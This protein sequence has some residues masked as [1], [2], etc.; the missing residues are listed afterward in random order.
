MHG[1]LVLLFGTFCI[2]FP[3]I[4]LICSWLNPQIQSTDMESQLYSSMSYGHLLYYCKDQGFFV[5]LFLILPTP[6]CLYYYSFIRDLGIWQ[7]TVH[8]LF[9]FSRYLGFYLGF[10][11]FHIN[12]R[13]N[14]SVSTRKPIPIMKGT[15]LTLQTNLER[16]NMFARQHYW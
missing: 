14:V 16:I 3:Q 7:S 2:F 5:C 1:K 9:S 12:F 6:H 15:T 13:I 11:F 8:S 10:P 4:F